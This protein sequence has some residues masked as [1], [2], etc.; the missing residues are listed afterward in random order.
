M[1]VLCIGASRDDIVPP[2]SARALID[3]V[4]SKDKEFME[5]E[6][7]HISVIAGRRAQQQVWPALLT[8]LQNHDD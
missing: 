7:G 1:P 2:A 4:G 6:G 5:L 3:S 8:W